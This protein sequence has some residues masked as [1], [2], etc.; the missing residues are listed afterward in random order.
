M[1]W[2]ILFASAIGSIFAL[3]A[4]VLLLW[5]EDL[6]RK[7]SLTFVSF[8]AG[9]LIAVALFDLLA[10][11]VELGPYDDVAVAV[12][13]G[14]LAVFFLEKTVAW[15]H[16]HEGHCDIHQISTS[17]VLVGDSVHNFVDGLVIA[18][19]FAADPKI[20]IA[21]TIAVFLHEVPQEIGDFG[22]LLHA[23]YTRAQVILFNIWT[24]SLTFVGALIGYY[25]LP[26]VSSALPV[27]FG[28]TA[29][30]FLYIATSDLL[31]ELRH[32]KG[33]AEAWHIMALVAGI[34]LIW[35]ISTY[36]PE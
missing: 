11:A 30:A 10:E 12:T 36:L 22:V 31:P 19:S 29:G 34:A 8:A 16:C 5:R 35:G 1:L 21:T 20:G 25:F 33:G 18:L 24:A 32:R 13:L 28:F 23:G 2:Q 17:M 7:F 14:I 4:G 15:H 3:L 27:I 26:Y 6:A 9:S